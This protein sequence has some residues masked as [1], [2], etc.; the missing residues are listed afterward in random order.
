MDFFQNIFPFVALALIG[1]VL[2]YAILSKGKK[3]K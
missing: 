1:L 3:M 2:L